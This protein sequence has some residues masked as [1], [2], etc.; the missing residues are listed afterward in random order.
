MSF[1]IYCGMT[2]EEWNK[3]VHKANNKDER[4]YYPN[5][6]NYISASEVQWPEETKKMAWKLK[7]DIY[8]KYKLPIIINEHDNDYKIGTVHDEFALFCIRSVMGHFMP[9]TFE[10]WIKDKIEF[11]DGDSCP[12]Y[13]GMNRIKGYYKNVK[14]FMMKF[15]PDALNIIARHEMYKTAQA[16]GW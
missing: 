1:P 11:S 6:S 14:E 4:G 12:E 2:K 13:C 7:T 15:D 9:T 16:G 8:N 3:M 10:D 5:G